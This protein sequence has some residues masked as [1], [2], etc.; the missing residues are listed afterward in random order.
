MNLRLVPLL[1]PAALLL[2]ALAAPPA[3]ADERVPTIRN[4]ELP[5]AGTCAPIRSDDVT[6]VMAG[7]RTTVKWFRVAGLNEPLEYEALIELLKQR[8]GTQQPSTH[9]VWITASARHA[10]VHVIRIRQAC[11]LAGIYR[12]GVRV[13]SE[14]T[15]KV[16]GFP[17]FLPPKV[18]GTP[19]GKAGLLRIRINTVG[20]KKADVVPGVEKKVRA[21]S[22]VGYVYAAAR[23]AVERRPR[24]AVDE[25]VSSLWIATNAPLQYA[26]SAIDLL[27]RG[28]CAGVK[29]RNGARVPP[30][31]YEAIPKLEIQGGMVS[32]HP[33]TLKAPPIEPR[34]QPWPIVGAGKPGWV[35]LQVVD[36][37]PAAGAAA[38]VKKRAAPAVRPNYA[39]QATGVP[40]AVMR[41]VDEGA[42]AWTRQ[43]GA[44]LLAGVKGTKPLKERF[45]IALRRDEV[46]PGI[47]ATV[48]RQFPDAT[49]IVPAT[50]QFHAFLFG[51]GKLRG[52]ADATLAMVGGRLQVVYGHWRPL[53]P[54][55]S[56]TLAPFAVDP[57]A[58]GDPAAW[59]IWFEGVFHDVKQRGRSALPLASAETVTPYFPAV[60]RPSV[61]NRIAG[62]GPALEQLAREIARTPYDRVVLTP[63]KGTAAVYAGNRVVGVLYF[64]LSAE[65]HE[66]RLDELTP[67]R[68]P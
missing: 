64:G 37:P 49:R 48:R 40:P 26:V 14:A 41:S 15:G 23:R 62:R 68:A 16:L 60:A 8:A 47:L 22:D 30:L 50:L 55:A 58:A 67:R 51:E 66:L 18:T 38:P 59:R 24:F 12:I 19:T 10:W 35:D 39:A 17:L 65:E 31:K 7:E 53:D 21:P 13:R 6:H 61:S 57:F 33:Q 20:Q 43:L 36:L 46:L 44:D 2:S 63:H 5:V 1:L 28:G 34:T 42:L 45:V 56:I 54:N 32:R 52:R 9:A 4:A 25:I 27:Y 11:L 29:L 3:A